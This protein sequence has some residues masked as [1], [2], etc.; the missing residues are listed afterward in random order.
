MTAMNSA[1]SQ[2]SLSGG[3]DVV[4]FIGSAFRF[5]EY[6]EWI[7]SRPA[8]A[9]IRLGFD[10]VVRCEKCKRVWAPTLEEHQC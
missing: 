7:L 6:E 9:S 10:P 2:G 4:E 1:S 5:E 3:S 8:G